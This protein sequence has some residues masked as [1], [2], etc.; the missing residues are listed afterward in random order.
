VDTEKPPEQAPKA[1]QDGRKT[2]KERTQGWNCY[3]AVYLDATWEAIPT[4]LCKRSVDISGGVGLD[5]ARS[6]ALGLL[7]VV[8]G[9][10]FRRY[11]SGVIPYVLTLSPNGEAGRV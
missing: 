8:N 5:L 3:P 4:L 10:E 9:G 11:L 6:T 7:C 2:G 1:S